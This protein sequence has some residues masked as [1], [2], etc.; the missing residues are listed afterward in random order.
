MRRLGSEP[1][2]PPMFFLEKIEKV[3]QNLEVK[4]LLLENVK[5]EVVAR[6]DWTIFLHNVLDLVCRGNLEVLIRLN[7]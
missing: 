6:E 4:Q 3:K 1:V 5:R 2:L 7:N